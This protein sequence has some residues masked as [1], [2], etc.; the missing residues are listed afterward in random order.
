MYKMDLKIILKQKFQ[1]H[2]S[3][4]SNNQSLASYKKTA[5]WRFLLI[6]WVITQSK[7]DQR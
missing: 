5:L 7:P 4:P 6:I 3:L 2:Q 1:L